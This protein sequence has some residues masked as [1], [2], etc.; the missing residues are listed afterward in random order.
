MTVGASWEK[1]SPGARGRHGP[2]G[3]GRGHVL[4]V[5]MPHRQE[6]CALVVRRFRQLR[7]DALDRQ[8]RQL[9]AALRRVVP[10]VV[11]VPVALA[12]A[13]AVALAVVRATGALGAVGARAAGPGAARVP[14]VVAVS[15][16]IRRRP[17]R[18]RRALLV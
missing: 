7:R 5:E 14:T 3:V 9:D 17:R 2:R 18:R 4:P 8:L 15:A 11:T 1:R 13:L 12:I 10:A 6:T 16:V